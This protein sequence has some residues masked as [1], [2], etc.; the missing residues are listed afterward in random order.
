MFPKLNSFHILFEVN[1]KSIK[2]FRPFEQK[3]KDNSFILSKQ[4]RMIS[5]F[6]FITVLFIIQH[7]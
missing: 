7:R 6:Q 1:I 2:K 4:S 3:I 5:P